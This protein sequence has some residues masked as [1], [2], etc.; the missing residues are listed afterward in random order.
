MG[1][2]IRFGSPVEVQRAG[3][4]QLAAFRDPANVAYLAGHG[5]SVGILTRRLRTGLMALDAALDAGPAQ[6]LAGLR[7]QRDD[8]ALRVEI[9]AARILVTVAALLGREK[10]NGLRALFP[11]KNRSKRV[12]E[13]NPTPQNEVTVEVGGTQPLSLQRPG[14]VAPVPGSA[15][16]E[17]GEKGT[18]AVPS[19]VHV[20]EPRGG[21]RAGFCGGW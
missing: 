10:R 7:V 13:E 15:A 12:A 1:Q 20:R 14:G 6:H 9:L 19:R 5:V 8:H 3:E 4:Q 2:V 18:G 21:A 11:V 17:G 16:K